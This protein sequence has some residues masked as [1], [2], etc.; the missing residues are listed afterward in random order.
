MIPTGLWSWRDR[1]FIPRP[2]G[3][4]DK[5]AASMLSFISDR[6]LQSS[7][8]QATQIDTTTLILTTRGL[9]VHPWGM[10][11]SISTA[12]I[13]IAN[14]RRPEIRFDLNMSKFFIIAI[15]ISF[16]WCVINL[17]SGFTYENIG[18]SVGGVVLLC[19][20]NQVIS[21]SRFRRW[22]ISMR[23]DLVVHCSR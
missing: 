6:A 1:I 12:K 17:M 22:L 2:E 14:V 5:F 21:A 3:L 18:I 4:D 13:S 7:G 9:D 8:V 20:V 19:F 15:C 23:D 10:W 11:F 16:F